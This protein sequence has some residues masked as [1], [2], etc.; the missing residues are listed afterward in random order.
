[1]AGLRFL[2][3]TP[4][5]Q[6]VDVECDEVQLTGEEGAFGVLP[7]HA[8][9]ISLLRIGEAS[10]RTGKAEHFAA[11]GAG[12]AEVLNDVVTALCDFAD[13]PEEIDLPEAQRSLAAAEDAMKTVG[14]ETFEAVS[15]Q[16][17]TAA[18]R[19][20]VASRR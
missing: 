16:L 13:L 1:M 14:P 12:F 8:R 7:G 17:Q 19:V 9:L 3:V 20:R 2:L 11:A 15:A 6:L 10:Y 18:A 5:R 4:Q